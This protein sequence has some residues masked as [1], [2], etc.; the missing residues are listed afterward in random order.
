LLARILVQARQFGSIIRNLLGHYWG[1][2]ILSL[3]AET[4]CYITGL[5]NWG[6]NMNGLFSFM[7]PVAAHQSGS[8]R[9]ENLESTST[10]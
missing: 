10:F 3:G 7:V 5:T 6:R 8:S 4:G 1:I 9:Q 2:P